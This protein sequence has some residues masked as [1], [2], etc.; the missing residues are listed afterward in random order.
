MTSRISTVIRGR[1]LVA[2][3]VLA[4]GI[5]WLFWIPT[6]IIAWNQGWTLPTPFVDL[7]SLQ[8]VDAWEALVFVFFSLAVFGPLFAALLVTYAS[9]GRPGLRELWGR[10]KKARVGAKWYLLVFLLPLLLTLAVAGIAI[11][12]TGSASN[13]LNP[14]IPF[15]LLL[16]FFLYQLLTSGLEEP[17]WRGYALPKLQ[18]GLSADKASWRLG[19]LWAFW[20]YPFVIYLSYPAVMSPDNPL[21]MAVLIPT[22]AGFTMTIVGWTYVLTWVYNST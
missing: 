10:M 12:M 4:F 2:Y 11:A 14:A 8:F 16:I 3:F 22:L 15:P 21:G 19:F 5:T 20:H 17:G 1:P 9:G 6:L 18:T 7:V 13:L